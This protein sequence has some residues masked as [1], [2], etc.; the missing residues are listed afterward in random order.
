M[1]TNSTTKSTYLIHWNQLALWENFAALVSDY[2]NNVAPQV[3]RRPNV[4]IQGV[5]SSIV[6]RVA[7]DSRVGDE[8]DVKDYIQDFVVSVHS[9]TSNGLNRA[10]GPT[11]QHSE[12]QRWEQDVEANYLAGIPDF[13]MAS[14]RGNQLWRVTAMIEVKNP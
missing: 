2:R 3:D 14:E 4:F 8:G 7:A 5:Y 1:L 13:V 12:L 11:D 9:A 6:Q 10:P